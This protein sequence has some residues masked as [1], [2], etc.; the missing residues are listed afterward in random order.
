MK[1]KSSSYFLIGILVVIA[2][3]IGIAVSM[4]YWEDKILPL[5]IGSLVFVL[6]AVQLLLELRSKKESEKVVKEEQAD[7]KAVNRNILTGI[8]WIT[9]AT[10]GVY[11]LGFLIGI[12]LFIIAYIKVGTKRWVPAIIIAAVTTAFIYL[13]FEFAM[14]F[15]LYRGL[16]Y[17]KIYDLIAG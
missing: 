16:I 5:I 9:G 13:S 4:R 2:V 6:A 1:I 8:G 11:I 10:I 17:E 12:F 7:T 3:A 14:E 15:E